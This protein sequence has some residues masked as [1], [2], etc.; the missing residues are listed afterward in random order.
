[1]PNASTK[2]KTLKEKEK[3]KGSLLATEKIENT[4]RI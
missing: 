3:M 4:V 2:I 1:V